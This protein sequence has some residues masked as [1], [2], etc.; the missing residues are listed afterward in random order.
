MPIF[1]HKIDQCNTDT[2]HVTNHY[3]PNPILL[4]ANANTRT[5]EQNHIVNTLR[6]TTSP[7]KPHST[8]EAMPVVASPKRQLVFP[9]INLPTLF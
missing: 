7:S 6:I 8:W 4:L 9:N 2:H 5:L 3:H 1:G